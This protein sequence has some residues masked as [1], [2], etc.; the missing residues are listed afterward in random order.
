MKRGPNQGTDF[1]HAVERVAEK[2]AP[3]GGVELVEK[4]ILSYNSA[5]A[6]Q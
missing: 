3:H 5:I 1:N 4:V 6:T 2:R